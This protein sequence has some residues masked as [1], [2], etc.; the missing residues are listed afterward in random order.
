MLH[1]VERGTSLKKNTEGMSRRKQARPSRATLEEDPLHGSR[2]NPLT[3]NDEQQQ[4]KQ[5]Q[6]PSTPRKSRKKKKKIQIA[7][8]DSLF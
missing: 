3:T 8:N 5:Q 6:E 1:F 4:Q 7:T 2:N